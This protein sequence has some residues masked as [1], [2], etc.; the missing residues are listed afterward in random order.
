M[1]ITHPNVVPVYKRNN[2]QRI[3]KYLPISLL[4]VRGKILEQL[5]Y[6]K[7]FESVSEKTKSCFK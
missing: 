3:E 6:N 1:E 5:I 4:P 2:K 7:M